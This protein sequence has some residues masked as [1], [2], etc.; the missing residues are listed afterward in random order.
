MQLTLLL[1]LLA[2]LSGCANEATLQP[3]AY[4]LSRIKTLLVV[5]MGSPPLRVSPDWIYTSHPGI[6][7]QEQT[8][9][10]TAIMT[11]Q[12]QPGPGGIPI[13]SLMN[14]VDTV[15]STEHWLLLPLLA[16]QVV[17]RLA[18]QGI[19]A[20]VSERSLPLPATAEQ[21]DAVLEIAIRDYAL[22]EDQVEVAVLTRLI[23][24]VSGAVWGHALRQ[25]MYAW[26]PA[27]VLLAQDATPFKQLVTEMGSRLVDAN[28]RDLGL[29]ER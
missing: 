8:V 18:T 12:V 3:P 13:L 7:M 1:L 27:A 5:P 9:P 22:W 4:H 24:P 21:T 17:T 25:T 20:A 10:L 14:M 2:S 26:G 29:V 6:A 15:S 23:D 19:A 16:R 28:L 11:P